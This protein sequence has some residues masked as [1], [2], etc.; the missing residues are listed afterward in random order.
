MQCRSTAQGSPACWR[1]ARRQRAAKQE[2]QQ[3]H[4]RCSAGVVPYFGASAAAQSAAALTA[5]AA[6]TSEGGSLAPRAAATFVLGSDEASCVFSYLS[7]PCLQ[8]CYYVCRTW[9]RVIEDT[10]TLNLAVKTEFL[11]NQCYDAVYNFGGMEHFGQENDFCFEP[12]PHLSVL[13][14][15]GWQVCR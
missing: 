10:C 8:A 13:T 3:R 7:Q 1:A 9:Q 11:E 2:Q 14:E 5:A 6:A 4:Q 12:H 15:N